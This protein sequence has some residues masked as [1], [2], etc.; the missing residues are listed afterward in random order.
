M[1]INN[2]M[3]KPFMT[4]YVVDRFEEELSEFLSVPNVVAVNS[5][6]SALIASLWHLGLSPGDEVITTP[7]TYQ[8]TI[9]AILIAGGTPV[10]VDINEDD[11]LI[12]VD[13]IEEA[14][15]DRTMAIIPVHLFGQSCAMTKI[16]DICRKH[17]LYLIEDAAQAFGLKLGQKYVGTFGDVGCFSFYK[18]KNLSTFQGG[19]IAIPYNSDIDVEKIR[20][21]CNN[22]QIGKY[23]FEHIGFNFEM[24]ELSALVGMERLLMHKKGITSELGIY[25]IKNGHYPRVAYDTPALHRLGITGNCPVAELVAERVRN[26]SFG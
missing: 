1:V 7:F 19:A 4:K 12:N 11:F 10:F 21:I 25:G 23:N 8:A 9:N 14:I 24:S 13:K 18:T 5:G 15:T 6:T 17:G 3:N 22:G 16:I 2:I 20:A 26:G